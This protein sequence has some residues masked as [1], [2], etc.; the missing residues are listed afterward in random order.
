MYSLRPG[1]AV[2]SELEFDDI[3]EIMN[4]IIEEMQ[5]VIIIEDEPNP[6]FINGLADHYNKKIYF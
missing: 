6:F 4:E 3:I 5:E 2:G 1:E